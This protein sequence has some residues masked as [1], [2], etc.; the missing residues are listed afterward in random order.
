MSVDDSI[1]V[2]ATEVV[3]E[4]RQPVAV[5]DHILRW[6]DQVL[7]GNESL[8]V[9]PIANKNAAFEHLERVFDQMSAP[10]FDEG[11]DED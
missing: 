7:S 1:T 4:A 3:K 8:I 6:Y 2:A 10:S 9:G 5:R 11:N